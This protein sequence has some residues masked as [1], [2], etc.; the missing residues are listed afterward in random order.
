MKNTGSRVLR[1]AKLRR[2]RAIRRRVFM[3]AA[4]FAVI[5]LI[6][7]ASI[8]T[9]SFADE[10]TPAGGRSKYYRSIEIKKG[11]TLYSI[12]ASYISSEY[13]GTGE[14]ID[15]VVRLNSLDDINS[16]HA[17]DHLIVPY[18]YAMK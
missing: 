6:V 14:Y 5:T 12:A 7:T 15:E 4:V 11:D 2:Q 16:I 1:R 17:G 9:R 10:K 8:S 3:F 13:S 18:F